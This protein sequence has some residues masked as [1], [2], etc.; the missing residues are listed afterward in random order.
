VKKK[1]SQGTRVVL[2]QEKSDVTGSEETRRVT[3]ISC[4]L[5]RLLLDR[6]RER[7]NLLSFIFGPKVFFRKKRKERFESKTPAKM[8]M[9]Q[10][11]E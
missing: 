5:E 7:Q 9:T 3:Q 4:E 8:M 2:F 11:H 10:H 1:K 6:E